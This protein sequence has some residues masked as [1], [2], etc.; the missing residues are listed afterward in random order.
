MNFKEIVSFLWNSDS[1]LAWII[2]IALAFVIVKFLVYP[3]FAL[4]FGT[5]Y[6]I[7]AV[8]S[9][10]MD[11]HGDFNNWWLSNTADCGK[12]GLCSQAKFYSMFNISKEDF[13]RFPLHNGFSRGDIIFLKHKDPSSIQKGDIIV[14]R[15]PG[16]SD[17]VIH[18]VIKKWVENG[19]YH[20]QTKGD[21]NPTSLLIELDTSEEDIVGVAFFRIPKLGYLKIWFADLLRFLHL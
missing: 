13:L 2:D 9:G 7:V 15:V 12:L 8:V 11:H 10:S 1:V 20:F 18:R 4:L 5:Q 21:H 16:L 14:F 19:T 3:G 17:P 6:P